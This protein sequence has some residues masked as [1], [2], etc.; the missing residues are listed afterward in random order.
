M[1]EERRFPQGSALLICELHVARLLFIFLSNNTSV[2]WGG[3]MRIKIAGFV[4]LGAVVSAWCCISPT[5]IEGVAFTSGET[6]HVENLMK[7]GTENVNYFK[8]GN[9]TAIGIRFVSHYDSRAMVFVGTYG[10]SYQQNLPLKCMGV[11]FPIDSAMQKIDTNMFDF[12][13]A[14]KTELEWLVAQKVVSLGAET[15]FRI[16]SAL[17]KA[18]N[19]GVQFWTHADTVL[20]Y[21]S[22]YSY[23][24]LKGTWGGTNGVRGVYG[25]KGC[26]LINPDTGLP[27]QQLQ[28]TGIRTLRIDSEP[29]KNPGMSI[30]Q[31]RSG[32]IRVCLNRPFE[33][34]AT[35]AI[36]N[37]R[38]IVVG[39]MRVSKNS[40][41]FLLA[42]DIR[43]ARGFYRVEMMGK[44]G[45]SGASFLIVK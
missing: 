3:C 39:R 9:D 10:M 6:L 2:K 15:M 4:I 41:G 45:S 13:T 24:T 14:V 38:G 25:V 5:N 40:K 36:L 28:G 20:E 19:G 23:D 34:S 29:N 21:N 32:E 22:W 35:L 42:P 1:R 27:P 7:L 43:L 12:A 44:K 16:D 18:S 26:S 11:I 33:K 31:G 37:Y 17:S 8:D 30:R